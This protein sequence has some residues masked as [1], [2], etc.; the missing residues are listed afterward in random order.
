MKK[1]TLSI[2][3]I[4]T[5]STFA[6]AETYP[7]YGPD[8]Y[9][10]KHEGGSYA[11]QE[12]DYDTNKAYIGLAYSYM[13]LNGSSLLSG[14]KLEIDIH[15]NA[16][17]LLAGYEINQY[18][19]IEG[20]YSKTINDLDM[21]L[22]VLRENQGMGLGGYLSNAGLYLKPKYSTEIVTLYGLLG[23]GYIKGDLDNIVD[24]SGAE[25]QWG[26]GISFNAGNSFIANSDVSLFMDYIR[27]DQDDFSGIDAVF[28]AFNF[29]LIFKF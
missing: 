1:I 27:Y 19:A 21:D 7:A 12:I 3:A 4:M 26:L 5:M 29:G 11:G 16:I 18:L 10:A 14:E 17:T 8:S 2:A 23:V 24:E 20:R 13:N 9:K 6:I 22:K 25:F 28:D 15:G